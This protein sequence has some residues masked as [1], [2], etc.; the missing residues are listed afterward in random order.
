M[1]YIK[2]IDLSKIKDTKYNNLIVFIILSIIAIYIIFTVFTSL[3][4]IPIIMFGGSILGYFIYNYIN[5][6]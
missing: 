3:L 2:Q 1:D 6:N 5:N 4:K